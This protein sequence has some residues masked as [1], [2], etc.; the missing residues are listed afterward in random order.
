M[1]VLA[2]RKAGFTLKSPMESRLAE[3]RPDAPYQELSVEHINFFS[4][5][6]LSDLFNAN[7]FET[8]SVGQG[9]R[10]QNENTTCPAAFGVYQ[11]TELA[12]AP[13]ER[14]V[15]AEPGLI[16]YIEE[17]S[18]VDAKIRTIIEK[19][20]QGRELLV[21]GTG[22]HTQRLLATGAF[23]NARI[24]AFI[25]SNPKFQGRTLHGVPILSPSEI[26][27]RTEPILI[28]TRGFQRE[29]QDQ[30]QNQL[31]LKNEVICLYTDDGDPS[32]YQV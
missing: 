12:A 9:V 8:V 10:Q 30:I 25:D 22:A 5:V 6:S 20:T 17:S 28:S 13:L 2:A 27:Q 14:D 26:A 21:W 4:T 15:L 7:G 31:N 3:R 29:I 18:S 16:R 32:K 19:A 24:A 1:P 11:K 23:A